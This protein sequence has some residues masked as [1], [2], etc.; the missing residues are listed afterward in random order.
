MKKEDPDDPQKQKREEP[1]PIKKEEVELPYFTEDD[2]MA[3]PTDDPLKSEEGQSETSRG[4]EPPSGSSSST[5]GLQEDRFIAPLSDSEDAMSHAPDSDDKGHRQVYS[6]DKRTCSQCGKTFVNKYTC[7]R[8]MRSHT[9]EKPFCCSVC[10]QRFSQKRG[11]THHTRT[12]TGE[13]PFPCSFCGQ[14]FTQKGG[15][16]IHERSHTGEKTFLGVREEVEHPQMKKEEPDDTQQ[17]KREEQFPIKKEE[18]ELLYVTE[19]DIMARPTGEPLKSEEGQSE[20]SR[21]VEPPSGSSSSTEGLQEDS[22]IAPLSDSED[23]MSHS[24][25]SDD[26]GHKQVYS[27]DKRTCSQCG[28]TFVNKYTCRRH[29]RN[30]TEEKPF[31]CSVCGQ[32]FSQKKGLTHHAR[33]HTGEKPFS[34]SFCGQRFTQKGGLTIHERSHT[35][36]KPFSCSVCGQR[37]SSKGSLTRHTRTHTGEKTFSS[38]VCGQRFSQKGNLKQHA[39]THTGEKP[40]LC[41]DVEHLQMKKEEPDES[42]QKN[43][44]EQLSIKKEEVEL[45]YVTEDDIMARPTGEP[46]MSEEG[47]SETSRGAEHP[48]GSS[49]STEGLQEGTFIAP[50]SDSEETMSHSPESDDEGHKQ[51]YPDNKC[52]Q[53]GKTFV[54]KYTCRRHM[55]IHTGEKPFSCSLCGQRFSVRHDLIVHTRSHTGEKPFSCSFCGQRFIQKRG[56]TQHTI[57]HHGKKPFSCS[58]CGKSFGHMGDLTKHTRTH[59]GEK[60]FTCSV[61][62]QGFSQKGGLTIHTR[63]HSGE[64][65]FSCSVCGKRFICKSHLTTHT[66]IHTGEKPFSCSVCGQRFS[67]K[68]NL[69]QHATTHT[70][71]KPFTCSSCGQVFTLKQNLKRHTKSHGGE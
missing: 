31:C 65:P 60:P 8:H 46:L 68:G 71:E 2:V 54:D 64:S 3:R 39:T 38:A 18:I 50:L 28:K 53:C 16:T 44:E 29:M 14:I 59:T 63:A 11:L 62:G 47:R 5:E 70:R 32:R 36:E 43:R 22:F 45:P 9:E 56:L 20:T 19:D 41:V 4:A 55:R 17:R 49:S 7:R 6:D 34:C 37:F 51:V 33:T 35:G 23:A 61:C 40:F 27:D 21:G 67:Q 26:K 42:Q 25:D 66:K 58:V 13:K 57:T 10:G 1:L 15:L 52:S 12:H 24:P 69:K 30:H 48:S